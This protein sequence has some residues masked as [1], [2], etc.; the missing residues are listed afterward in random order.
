MHEEEPGVC[1][2]PGEGPGSLELL[3]EGRLSLG[4]PLQD[5]RQLKMGLWQAV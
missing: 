2:P 3:G 4:W 5:L 1:K